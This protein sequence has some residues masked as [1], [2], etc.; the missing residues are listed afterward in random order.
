MS[1]YIKDFWNLRLQDVKGAL[2]ENNFKAWVVQSVD[3]A[4]ELVLGELVPE[5]APAS[6]SWGGSLT[7]Q[8]SGLYDALKPGAAPEGIEVIDTYDKSQGPEVVL[9]RRRQALLCD[10]F[11][12]GTN[13]VTETGMLVNLDMYGNRVAALVFG[14]KH[15]IVLAGRNKV[16]PDLDEAVARIKTYAAPAN[17]MKLGKKT[18]CV[19][20]AVCHDCK[21]PER[22]CNAWT[23]NEKCFPEGRIRVVL[24]NEDLGL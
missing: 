22:I 10:L 17:A 4:R 15:V 20:T 7:F 23:I 18:P 24:V 8:A 3:E 16:V 11:I 14:P 13:A 19:K 2:E 6:M 12:T 1:D 5:I 9:E 21:S